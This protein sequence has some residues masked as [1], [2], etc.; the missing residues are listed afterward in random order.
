MIPAPHN[1]Q[2]G[3]VER[4]SYS[5]KLDSQPLPPPLSAAARLPNSDAPHPSRGRRAWT[6][7]SANVCGA[8][9]SPSETG[10]WA[11]GRQR[12]TRALTSESGGGRRGREDDWPGGGMIPAGRTK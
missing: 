6:E 9:S 7:G 11:V 8:T 3:A 2:A 10:R 5:K 1:I 12:H 4:P